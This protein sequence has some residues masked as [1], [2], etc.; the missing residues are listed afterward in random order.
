V[1]A[2]EVNTDMEINNTTV[3]NR[4]MHMGPNN[5]RNMNHHPQFDVMRMNFYKN[6]LI[7]S[8]SAPSMIGGVVLAV[9]DFLR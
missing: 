6:I 7:G 3:P 1:V 5:L 4:P 8:W 9:E 2:A